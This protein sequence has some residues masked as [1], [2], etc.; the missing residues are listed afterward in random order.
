MK[1]IPPEWRSY[2]FVD[3]AARYGL[4]FGWLP[5][6]L[7]GLYLKAQIGLAAASIY[8]SI[9]LVLWVLLWTYFAFTLLRV[10]CPRCKTPW[11]GSQSHTFKTTRKCTNCSLGLYEKP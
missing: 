1:T 2:R 3:R 6:V 9:L 10:P 8:F 7:L 5:A 11:L 4:L